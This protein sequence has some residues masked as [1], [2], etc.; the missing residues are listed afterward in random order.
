MAQEGEG[1]KRG[2]VQVK[3]L[4]I[5]R[6]GNCI[7]K[8]KANEKGTRLDGGWWEWVQGDRTGNG[9]DDESGIGQVRQSLGQ[10]R[11]SK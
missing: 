10:V 9:L 8:R 3:E 5:C 6:V 7:T 4:E 11:E 2:F 1:K